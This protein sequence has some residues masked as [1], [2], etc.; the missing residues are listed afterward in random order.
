MVK[1][2][3]DQ[4]VE[5][6]GTGVDLLFCNIEEAELFTGASGLEEVKE[7][8]KKVAK[9]FVIT[10]SEKGSLVYD[11]QNFIDI[12]PFPTKAVDSTGAGDM[13]AGAYLYAINHGK[14]HGE[15]GLLA[16]A[17]S[18]AVVGKFGPRLGDAHIREVLE[19]IDAL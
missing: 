11:G 16:S 1:Y 8:L 5:V 9:Q 7:A 13:F 15:A 4:M 2:F 19:K 10:R 6:V 3:R 14:T 17:A 12:K 18:S